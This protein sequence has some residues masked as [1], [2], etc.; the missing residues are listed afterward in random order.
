[1]TVTVMKANFEKLQPKVVNFT[2]YNHYKNDSD[3]SKSIC[4]QN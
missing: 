4:C 2:D 1:M 3:D